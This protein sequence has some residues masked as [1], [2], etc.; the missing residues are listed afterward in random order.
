[1]SS[2][3]SPPR[4]VLIVEDDADVLAALVQYFEARGFEVLAAADGAE[5]L[6]LIESER[7]IDLLVADLVVPAANGRSLIKIAEFYRPE[8]QT[9]VITGMPEARIPVDLRARTLRKPFGTEELDQRLDPLF[10]RP[11]RPS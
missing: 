7:Y 5:A 1:M 3:P 9:V 2:I 8:I 11:R 10:G 4:S 6:R